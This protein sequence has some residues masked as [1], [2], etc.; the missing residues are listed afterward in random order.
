MDNVTSEQTSKLD[1]RRLAG[2]GYMAADG[3]LFVYGLLSYL[4][5]KGPND[6]ISGKGM[7]T[8]GLGW[9]AGGAILAKYGK[10]P[11]SEQLQ[12]VEN[13]LYAYLRDNGVE[14]DPEKLQRADKFKKR[15]LAQKLEDFLYD[16]PTEVLNA[17]YGTAA[18]GMLVSG[19][20]KAD[21]G[22]IMAASCVIAGALAGIFIKEKSPK[23]LEKMSGIKKLIHTKPLAISSGLYMINNVGSYKSAYDEQRKTKDPS[24]HLYGDKKYLLKYTLASLYVTSTLLMGSG[25]KK[26]GG[27]QQEREQAQQQLLEQAGYILAQQPGSVRKKLAPKLAEYLTKQRE[28]RLEDLDKHELAEQLLQ[29]A[30][31]SSKHPIAAKQRSHTQQQLARRALSEEKGFYLS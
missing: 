19:I 13:K 29:L 3:A 1:R 27:S 18:L 4:N 26:A 31:K 15:S 11:V 16:Y 30:A 25:S 12:R 10:Q 5:P 24:S 2:Y 14:L 21:K 22:E 17:Y 23:E 6:K 28:L 20:S 9:A 8:T 7:M